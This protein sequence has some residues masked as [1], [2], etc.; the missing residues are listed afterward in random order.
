MCPCPLIQVWAGTLVVTRVPV[1]R[2]AQPTHTC[3]LG[4]VWY[5]DFFTDRLGHSVCLHVPLFLRPLFLRVEGR[6]S[7][8]LCRELFCPSD[9][10][11]STFTGV[12]CFSKFVVQGASPPDWKALRG[13]WKSA[14]CFLSLLCSYTKGCLVALRCRQSHAARILRLLRPR[15]RLLEAST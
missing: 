14:E 6:R 3:G 15:L 8:G 5:H 10:V 9:C 7:S 4:S 2:V 11:R 12:P 1:T 13:P